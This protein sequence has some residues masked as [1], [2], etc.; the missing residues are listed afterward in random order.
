MNPAPA[1]RD[2]RTKHEQRSVL[3]RQDWRHVTGRPWGRDSNGFWLLEAPESGAY[4]VEMIFKETHPAGKATI[5]PVKPAR[6]WILWPTKSVG[7]RR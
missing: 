3:T 4:E 6:S 1:H 7:T 2:R 5:T